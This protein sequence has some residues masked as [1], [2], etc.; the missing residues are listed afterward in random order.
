MNDIR[1]ILVLELW[2]IGDVVMMSAILKPLREA[3]PNAEICV[4]TQAHGRDV[5]KENKEISRFYVF[6]FPWTAFRGKY[7]VWRWD[8]KG[9]LRII[10]SLRQEKFDIVL[11][12]RGDPRNDVL[13]FL[14]AVRRKISARR[15]FARKHR[16]D[17]WG[18]LLQR[19][20]VKIGKL[21]PF[22]EISTPELAAAEKFLSDKFPTRPSFVVG[23]HPGA[24]Q[25]ARCWPLSR[26]QEVASQ[27]LAR[28]VGVI[29]LA[30]PEGYGEELARDLSLPCCRG[31]VRDLAALVSRLDL[32]LCNDTGVMHIATA[33]QT[34]VVA[35][36]GPGDPEFIGPRDGGD[37]VIKECADRPC[38]DT[39]R[40]PSVK[41]L[42]Q[43][44]VD[45]VLNAVIRRMDLIKGKR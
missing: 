39:C 6:K 3:F 34:P 44:T 22:I 33:V 12:A 30:E 43:V 17:H 7:F 4:L 28:N 29:I 1:K 2:G 19:L 27:L 18:E 10:S 9:I 24:G 25:R 15:P 36:F 31:G 26:F 41:C 21:Q 11:D 42:Q 20:G 5:L 40:Q 37:V 23:I 8:W 32:V 13:S 16:I 45:D 35:V 38:F 14:I